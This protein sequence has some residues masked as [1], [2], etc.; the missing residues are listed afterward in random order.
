MPADIHCLQ[1]Y[2]CRTIASGDTAIKHAI[3]NAEDNKSAARKSP[4]EINVS[5]AD[6]IIA[7]R[8]LA[9]KIGKIHDVQTV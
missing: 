7:G 8:W 1:R 2:H 4:K 6:F 3:E 9:N 5:E